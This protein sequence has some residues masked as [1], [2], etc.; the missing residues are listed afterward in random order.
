[1]NDEIWS[2]YARLQR[3]LRRRKTVDDASWGHEAALDYL[4]TTAENQAKKNAPPISGAELDAGVKQTIHTAARMERK[5]RALLRRNYPNLSERDWKLRH[6]SDYCTKLRLEEMVERLKPRDQNMLLRR[7]IGY[8]Y[9]EL[10][11]ELPGDSEYIRKRVHQL[12]QGLL[13]RAA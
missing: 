1:M 7:A 10:A 4:I 9:D 3:R 8:S 12:R 2:R 5:H 13:A 6:W 11:K